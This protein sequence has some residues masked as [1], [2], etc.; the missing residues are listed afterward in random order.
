VGIE[1][2]VIRI[3]GVPNAVVAVIEAIVAV[4]G[5]AIGVAVCGDRSNDTGM[6]GCGGDGHGAA[7]M[8]CGGM[9]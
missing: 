9:S 3:S 1:V 4:A 6:A 7:A 8:V 5:M 2:R